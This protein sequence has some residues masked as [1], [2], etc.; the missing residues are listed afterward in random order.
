MGKLAG[1]GGSWR[2][3]VLG[4]G[5][6]GDLS[7]INMHCWV[8]EMSCMLLFYTVQGIV[9]LVHAQFISMTLEVTMHAFLLILNHVSSSHH[10]VASCISVSNVVKREEMSE[11]N[12]TIHPPPFQK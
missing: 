11:S 7:E 1:G 6:V 8:N 3:D 9:D 10:T 4:V 2:G 5:V 12:M